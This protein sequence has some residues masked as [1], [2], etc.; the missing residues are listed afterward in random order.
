[1]N[2]KIAIPGLLKKRRGGVRLPSHFIVTATLI[3]T[4]YGCA[5][6]GM[7]KSPDS[8]ERYMTSETDVKAAIMDPLVESLGIEILF[9]RATAN[10]KMLDL[11]YRVINPDLAKEVT[12]RNSNL[13]LRVVDRKSGQ[14]LGVPVTHIGF[15][16]TKTASPKKNRVYYV[17]FDNPESVVKPGSEVSV[18]FGEMRVEGLR[19]EDEGEA[20]MM[21]HKQHGHEDSQGDE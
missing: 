7:W 12:K 14:I 10:G 11:R 18:L 5:S 3:L 21:D 17:L 16:R 2:K 1:M 9:L 13:D 8:L 6:D 15:L 4:I 19:V 20:A